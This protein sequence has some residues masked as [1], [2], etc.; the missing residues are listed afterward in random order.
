M[1]QLKKMGTQKY[2]AGIG[3]IH[4]HLCLFKKKQDL[5]KIKKFMLVVITESI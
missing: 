5:R 3:G 2:C 4:Y 1:V